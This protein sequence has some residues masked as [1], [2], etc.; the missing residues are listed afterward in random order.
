MHLRALLLLKERRDP[1]PGF[2]DNRQKKQGGNSMKA[3]S[4]VAIHYLVDIE[5]THSG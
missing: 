3:N 2:E 1:L 5:M 4:A